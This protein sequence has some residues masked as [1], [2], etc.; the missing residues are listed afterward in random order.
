MIF[1]YISTK[2]F[3]EQHPVRLQSHEQSTVCLTFAASMFKSYG[4][5]ALRLSRH[6]GD[7]LTIGLRGLGGLFQL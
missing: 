2:L 5:V 4:D 3:L 1:S 6:V 7:E